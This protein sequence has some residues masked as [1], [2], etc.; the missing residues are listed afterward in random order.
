M[1]ITKREHSLQCLILSIQIPSTYLL[2]M[3]ILLLFAPFIRI[4]LSG[5]FLHVKYLKPI[6]SICTGSLFLAPFSSRTKIYLSP[7][8]YDRS[9]KHSQ[10]QIPNSHKLL[11]QVCQYIYMNMKHEGICM[12]VLLLLS[13]F[14][15]V[16]LCETP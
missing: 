10:I 6:E 4:E 5:N 9:L 15:R 3:T 13:C 2:Y 14:S 8:H 12:C 16:R 7:K 11:K 1:F